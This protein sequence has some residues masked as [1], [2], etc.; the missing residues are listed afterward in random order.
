MAKSPTAEVVEMVSAAKLADIFGCS[1]V[2]VGKLTKDGVI[3][4]ASKG[5]YPKDECCKKYIAHLKSDER[6]STKSAGE[7]RLRDAKAAE[8]DMRLAERRR[9]LIPMSDAD[10]A[11]SNLCGLF[12][13]EMDGAPAAMT[14]DMDWRR[15]I[16]AKHDEILVRIAR[17]SAA[18]LSALREGRDPADA[19]EEIRA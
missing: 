2:Y 18:I 3:A 14:R 17:R 1:V 16:E 5:Q 11:I 9:E 12:R 13:M 4:R 8:V 19:E 7:N 6:R 10:A 15:K